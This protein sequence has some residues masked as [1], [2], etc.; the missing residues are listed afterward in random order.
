LDF[1][2]DVDRGLAVVRAA[3]AATGAHAQSNAQ[4][5]PLCTSDDTPA[6]KQIDACNKIIALKVFSGEKLTIY[7]WRAVGW[8]KKGDYAKVIADTSEALRLKLAEK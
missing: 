8:N 6:D 7:F 3:C 2:G 4:L 1:D 5:G